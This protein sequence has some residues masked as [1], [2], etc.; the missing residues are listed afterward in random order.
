MVFSPPERV[1]GPLISRLEAIESRIVRACERAGR[2]RSAVTLVAV[3]KTYPASAIREAMAAGVR[4]FGENRVQ[5]LKQKVEEIPGGLAGG[6]AVWHMIGHIQRNKVRD[7]VA[8]A[9]AVHSVDSLRLAEE[10]NDRA[11]A[12]GRHIPCFVQVNVSGEASKFGLDPEALD[13][14]LAG[15]APLDGL[16]VQGFMTLASPAANPE[17]VRPEFRMLREFYEQARTR[18]A[19]LAG[20]HALSMGMSGD[21]E[22]AI[23]EGATHVRIG[24]ALFGSRS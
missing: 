7:V 24:S 23:E 8:C 14:L 4:H 3:S 13:P 9:D 21:F 17:S 12:A 6:E 10:L 22:V 18:Y 5:E 2:P 20:M 11:L 16:Q 15:L 19:H 1:R